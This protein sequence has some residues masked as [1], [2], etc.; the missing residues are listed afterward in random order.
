MATNYTTL[1]LTD[2]QVKALTYAI[3]VTTLSL[4]DYTEEEWREFGHSQKMFAY[5]CI[6][7]KLQKE[8]WE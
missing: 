4:D 3:R 7:E 2:A 5:K 8:G 6:T 1:K